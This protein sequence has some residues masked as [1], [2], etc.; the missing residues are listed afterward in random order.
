MISKTIQARALGGTDVTIPSMGVGTMLWLPNKKI[1][2]DD[3]YQ[4]YVA[5]VDSGLTFFDTAEIYGNGTSERIIGQCIKKDGRRVMIASK[6]APPSPMMP[7]KQKRKTVPADSPR[8]LLEALDG[9]LLRLGVDYLDLYQMHAPPSNNSIADYMGVMAEA[10]TAGKVRA[11]GVCNFSETQIREAH[12]ALAKHGIQLA[13]AMVGYN[14]LRRWP[15]TNGTF[16]ACKELNISVIPYA[17]LAEGILTGKYRNKDKR[18]PLGYKVA[19]YFGHL[20]ITKDQNNS[21]SLLQRIF[22][23]PLELDSRRLEPLF[24]TMD[25]IAAVHGKTFAQVAINWLL[26]NEEVC[27]I[28]IPG[29][30]SPEQLNDNIG[31]LGWNLTNDERVR[32]DMALRVKA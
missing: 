29:I 16:S 18:V 28:P 22:S 3:I 25:E 21:K 13:T 10:V 30:K 32:I 26:S 6:F 4:T 7:I 5:C 20:N 31:A 8:A 2:G 19:L 11:V 1:T 15:E 12:T 17:P 24:C 23:K 14:L 9:S 27:V